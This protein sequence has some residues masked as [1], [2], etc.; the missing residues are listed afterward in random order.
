MTCNH[1]KGANQASNPQPSAAQLIGAAA[2]QS[3]SPLRIAGQPLR[4]QVP[5]QEAELDSA[6]ATAVVP[7]ATRRAADVAA[8]RLPIVILVGAVTLAG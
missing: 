3:A 2:A 1:P 8:F 6:D 5:R 4:D 7:A